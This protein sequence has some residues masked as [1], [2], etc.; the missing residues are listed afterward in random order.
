MRLLLAAAICCLAAFAQARPLERELPPAKTACWERV[1]DADHLASHPQQKV[2]R[3][4]LVHLPQSW[5]EVGQGGFYVA[6]YI[7]LRQRVKPDQ[8]FDYQLG[9][10]CKASGQGLRCVPEWGAGSWRIERGPNGTLDVRNGGIIANPNP[11]DAEEIADGAAKIP[12]KP[13]DG[14]W[15]LSP[16]AGPC[17]LE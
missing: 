10:M 7:N 8:S 6:L 14:L 17:G 11:Y 13:D 15:R 4:R 1:Y 3:V 2:A 16:A 9:G 5:A 12:A